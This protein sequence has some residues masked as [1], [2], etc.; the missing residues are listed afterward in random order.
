MIDNNTSFGSAREASIDNYFTYNYESGNTY[1]GEFSLDEEG[2]KIFEGNGRLDFT[3]RDYYTG[4]FKVDK[5]CGTGTYV[6]N[7]GDEYRGNFEH[8][9]FNGIGA[10]R[11]KD[12]TVFHGKF[13]DD[14]RIGKFLIVFSDGTL[15]ETILQDDKEILSQRKIITVDDVNS[16]KYS[17]IGIYNISD[18]KNG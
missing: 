14:M 12:G 15:V 2:N 17:K 10:Y 8:D 13:R 9:K 5:M 16:Q 3:N 1:T 11:Y 7:C 6:F 4:A 18:I